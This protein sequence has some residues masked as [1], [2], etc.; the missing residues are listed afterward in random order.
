MTDW[1]S[2]MQPSLA[3]VQHGEICNRGIRREMLGVIVPARLLLLNDLYIRHCVCSYFLFELRSDF[4][5][6]DHADV[7]DIKT[8]SVTRGV[9]ILAWGNGVC[10]HHSLHN[11]LSLASRLHS[12]VYK[13]IERDPTRHS[14]AW[15]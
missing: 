15:R 7:G 10:Q 6:A 13:H 8:R 5:N 4:Y 11:I 9:E 12:S 14:R 1:G 2:V 3:F